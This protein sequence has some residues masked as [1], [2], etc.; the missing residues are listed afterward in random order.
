MG[1]N[2]EEIEKLQKLKKELPS[3]TEEQLLSY[4]FMFRWEAGSLAITKE[5]ERRARK[6]QHEFNKEIV[7]EQHRLNKKT[8]WITVIG[9]IGGTILGALVSAAISYYLM[10]KPIRMTEHINIHKIFKVLKK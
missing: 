10:P 3:L 4:E 6:E 2:E 7:K 5:W 8:V 9:T 1:I